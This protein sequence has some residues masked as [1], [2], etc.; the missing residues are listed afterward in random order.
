VLKGTPRGSEGL[1]AL[2]EKSEGSKALQEESECSKALEEEAR[3]Q[4][5]SKR[6]DGSKVLDDKGLKAH[7]EGD[8]ARRRTL[9]E[10]RGLKAL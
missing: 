3:A 4:R 1:K 10:I 5:R 6:S 8:K 7:L 2:E 9:K